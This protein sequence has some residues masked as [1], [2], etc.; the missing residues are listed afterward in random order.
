MTQ[1]ERAGCHHDRCMPHSFPLSRA[2]RLTAICV[3]VSV[4]LAGACDRPERSAGV[5]LV[6]VPGQVNEHVSIASDGASLV[7]MAWSASSE[8]D[9]SHIFAAVS[10]DGGASFGSPVRVNAIDRP[11]RVNGEQP[12]GSR[13]GGCEQRGGVLAA[14]DGRSRR[15]LSGAGGNE[16][17][18]SACLGPAARGYAVTHRG[19]AHLRLTS[20][21]PRLARQRAAQRCVQ[22]VAV[23]PVS[24]LPPRPRP[25]TSR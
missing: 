18:C 8:S 12:S 17:R 15:P 16:H 21:L 20:A 11:A 10:A 25:P 6:G 3:V 24:T 9:G 14:L 19:D 22:R 1:R 2:R 4:G 7:A 13:P 5:S 23:L